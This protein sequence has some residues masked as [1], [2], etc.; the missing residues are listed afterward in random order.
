ME[1]AILFALLLAGVI[2]GF[3]TGW[4]VFGM[5]SREILRLKDEHVKSL[6]AERDKARQ[7][8]VRLQE[9]N[10]RLRESN[11]HLKTQVEEASKA[12]DEKLRLLDDAQARLADSF[13]AL[14]SDALHAN[15]R[16]F[17][18]LARETLEKYQQGAKSDLEARQKAID[19]LLRPVQKSL[20]RVDQTIVEPEKA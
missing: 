16:A 14:S 1:Q 15:N 10:A 20:S 3:L 9:E 8:A 19:E 5:Q 4:L 12:A 11:A 7:E 17:L 2:A 6:A 13:K 18:E